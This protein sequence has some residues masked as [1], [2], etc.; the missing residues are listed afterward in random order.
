MVP[1][2][3]AVFGVADR[4]IGHLYIVVFQPIEGVVDA[5]E[6]GVARQESGVARPGDGVRPEDGARPAQVRRRKANAGRP[7]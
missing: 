6:G 5:G 1:P 4:Q 7:R 2:L 3:G